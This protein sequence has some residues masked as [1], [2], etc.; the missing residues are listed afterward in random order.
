MRRVIDR[1]PLIF[2]SRSFSR[3]SWLQPRRW[4]YYGHRACKAYHAGWTTLLR[5]C[6]RIEVDHRWRGRWCC[7]RRR[8]LASCGRRSCVSR[9]ESIRVKGD[10]GRLTRHS[11]YMAV[12]IKQRLSSLD[13][14][15]YQCQS[16]LQ[17]AA[18]NAHKALY[19][20]RISKSTFTLRPKDSRRK[21]K[22]RLPLIFN[23]IST[24]H[25]FTKYK[26][27]H[28]NNSYK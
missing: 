17:N 19:S 18:D 15:H 14:C 9:V 28:G 23:T 2:L 11:T 27:C 26:H 13:F 20:W 16:H 3:D 21:G 4:K 7:Q 6:W 10:I 8:A 12:H 5:H 24:M 1:L 25:V 22:Q